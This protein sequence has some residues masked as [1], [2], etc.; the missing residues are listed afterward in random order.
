MVKSSLIR[1]LSAGLS[2]HQV[3][4]VRLPTDR[5]IDDVVLTSARESRPTPHGDSR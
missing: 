3:V 1:C 2:T 5:L 4:T